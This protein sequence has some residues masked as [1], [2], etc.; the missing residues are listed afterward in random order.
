MTELVSTVQND[1]LLEA[2]LRSERLRRWKF[3]K[4]RAQL[5]LKDND[6]HDPDTG[7][8]CG[9]GGGGG[10]GGGGGGGTAAPA[11]SAP[12][13]EESGGGSPK[14]EVTVYGEGKSQNKT[15][16]S[17]AVQSLPDSHFK[18]VNDVRFTS[19]PRIKAGSSIAL[20]NYAA[21]QYNSENRHI[22]VADEI[23]SKDG[24]RRN[25]DVTGVTYH[26]VGHAIDDV[27]GLSRKLSDTLRADF[28]K[29]KPEEKYLARYWGQ[30]DKELFAE[31]YKLAF[32]PAQKSAFSM[33][34]KRAGKVFSKSIEAIRK[35]FV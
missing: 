7:E 29:M 30:S 26:E 34:Y 25:L 22:R 31:A 23:P 11:S 12:K 4:L 1:P 20:T 33:G 27:R 21:G 28:N 10:N 5:H 13:P 6:C 32:S 15:K 8:F 3:I 18:Y 19:Q 24:A 9:D 17:E 35:E 14:R 2:W 16:I